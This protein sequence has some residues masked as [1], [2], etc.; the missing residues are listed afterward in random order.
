[1][2]AYYFGISVW[3]SKKNYFFF[4]LNEW[5]GYR[6]SSVGKIFAV[7][8]DPENLHDGRRDSIP[9]SAHS[10]LVFIH[11]MS[12]LRNTHRNQYLKD[13]KSKE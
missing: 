5:L 7:Q 3:N 2:E 12:V 11:V 4:F 13:Y 8:S 10:S 6:D 1:M 9:I